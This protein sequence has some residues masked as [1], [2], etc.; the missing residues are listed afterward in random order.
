MHVKT[1]DTDLAISSPALRELL[2]YWRGRSDNEEM[3]SR[4]DIDPVDIPKLLPYI[5][6]ADVFH[7]PLRF[8]HRLLGTFITGFYE[9]DSTG[10]WLGENLYGDNADDIFWFYQQ[11]VHR[12]APVAV[13]QLIPFIRKDWVTLEALL[14]PLSDDGNQINMVFGGIAMIPGPP[15]SENQIKRIVLDCDL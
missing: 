9:R 8:R 4:R 15:Q 3:P 2:E 13:R 11:C 1:G 7:D 5:A 6:M 10:E 12:R 14:M